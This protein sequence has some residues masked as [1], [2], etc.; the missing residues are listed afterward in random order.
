MIISTFENKMII[1]QLVKSDNYPYLSSVHFGRQFITVFNNDNATLNT[2]IYIYGCISISKTLYG[3][4]AI[5]EMQKLYKINTNMCYTPTDRP[6]IIF[7]DYSSILLIFHYI[8]KS[9]RF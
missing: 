4:N 1:I 2:D 5:N 3:P 6:M 7:D 8:V 9:G